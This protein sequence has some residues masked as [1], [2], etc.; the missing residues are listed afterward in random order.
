VESSNVNISTSAGIQDKWV[1]V[2]EG[3]KSPFPIS[4]GERNWLNGYFKVY[5]SPIEIRIPLHLLSCEDLSEFNSWLLE[6][7]KGKELVNDFQFM[8]AFHS[9]RHHRRGE[10][11]YVSYMFNESPLE[12]IHLKFDINEVRLLQLRIESLVLKF[13]VT[14]N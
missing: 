10:H 12:R 8:D 9:F 2:V 7:L 3:F 11:F 14:S 4:W 1:L 6:V 13:P 5:R